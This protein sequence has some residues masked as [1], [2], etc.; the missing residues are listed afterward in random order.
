[1]G[2]WLRLVK[3]RNQ[4]LKLFIGRLNLKDYA[5]V[6]E[7]TGALNLESSFADRSDS[8][9]AHL[10]MRLLRINRHVLGDQAV[11]A[12]KRESVETTRSAA[13]LNGNPDV[14]Q[15]HQTESDYK[16]FVG[17]G[18]FVLRLVWLHKPKSTAHRRQPE[19]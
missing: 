12:V 11:L 18:V 19:C 7:A 5:Q 4:P 16:G 10:K 13:L 8:A 14:V 1:M 17:K 2:V 9:P 3:R 15:A 6:R